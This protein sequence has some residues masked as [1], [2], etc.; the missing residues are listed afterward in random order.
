MLRTPLPGPKAQAVVERDQKVLSPSYTRSYPL[1]IARGEGAIVEDVDGNRFLDMNAGIAV[2]ATG[3]AHPKVVAAVREQAEKFLHM[4]G[5]DFY[6]ENMVE[7]AEKL[8]AL[9]PGPDPKRV[10]FGN[11]GAE[12][13]E[14][15]L[16]MARYHTGRDKFV[17][18]LGGFHG[19]TMGALS[20]TGSKSV[21]KK[22]FAP[23]L[24]GVTHIPYAYCYR[25]A[26][27]KQPE[28]CAV[29]CVQVLEKQ[30]FPTILPAEEVAAVF[31][32]PVQGEGGYVVPPKK[33][34]DELR[35]VCD[36]HGILLV[37]DE[38]QCGMGRTGKLFASD[39]FGLEPDIIAMAKGI[40]SGLP[41]SATVAKA[42]YMQW[43]PG[44]HASTFGGNP[45][46]VAASLATIELLQQELIDN[47]VAIGAHMRQ[48]M[49]GWVSRF[50]VIGDVRGLGLM[51]AFEV[52]K[53]KQSKE[54]APELRNRI[55]QLAFQRGVLVLGA[56]QNSIRLSPPLVLSK[57]QADY[58]MAVLEECIGE[59]CR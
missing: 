41:L 44:A 13:I 7:L 19:R 48:R 12:A 52:V 46:S 35:A 14:A 36:R 57:D 37:A 3:H 43:K 56:G 17:A 2:V 50:P 49:D 29:E 8:A 4:S 15:A 21:Q 55:E 20:L 40:A 42:Q 27:G 28:T 30:L 5:T 23:L 33:F 54:R 58:A 34:F 6:Y 31:V 53:D 38:V 10:Y 11:S 18:F 26:Y 32:E 59:V 24:G 45:V 25:C 51:L 16:K 47:A 1:V 22:G 39:N 9:A